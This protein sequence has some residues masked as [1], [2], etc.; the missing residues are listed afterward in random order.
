LTSNL[1][2][3][4]M[5]TR[6]RLLLPDNQYN[7]HAI[8]L[9]T[10]RRAW[11][12]KAWSRYCLGYDTVASERYLVALCRTG[13]RVFDERTGRR[14]ARWARHRGLGR[15]GAVARGRI[16]YA[17]S[18]GRLRAIDVLT[19][20][21][22]WH[23]QLR[24][25]QQTA[26][27][28][29]YVCSKG[30]QIIA[31]DLATGQTR[32]KHSIGS[33]GVGLAKSQM[34]RVVPGLKT[35]NGLVVNMFNRGMGYIGRVSGFV[36][37]P[38]AAVT[39]RRITVE[40]TSRINGRVQPRLKVWIGD[41]AVRS[42]GRGRYRIVVQAKTRIRVAVDLAEA[43]RRSRLPCGYEQPRIVVPPKGARRVI[44]PID[45][46]LHP[47]DPSCGQCKCE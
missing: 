41:Q 27:D 1:L 47:L 6:S 38:G 16:L 20:R 17:P 3:Y 30:G 5:V 22:R 2:A 45:I 33:C 32:W 29:L 43:K 10:G 44:Q 40:G 24:V 7:L 13:V 4:A 34:V 42:D 28:H 23:R 18:G 26:A 39:V 35:G 15:Q 8:D 37:R 46:R 25:E 31:L 14:V 12:K 9:R 19:G 11:F 36:R 21:E